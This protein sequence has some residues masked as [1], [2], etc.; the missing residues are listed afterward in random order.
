MLTVTGTKQKK[1]DFLSQVVSE[2]SDF[3]FGHHC[4]TAPW[5][6]TCKL[7][8]LIEQI[9]RGL[10]TRPS[11]KLHV[12]QGV[13]TPDTGY[14]LKNMMGSLKTAVAHSTMT[15]LLAWLKSKTRCKPCVNIVIADFIELQDFPKAVIL[16][17]LER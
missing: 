7:D 15:A 11:E 13:L 8:S 3:W 5:A 12:V 14:I 6:N 4:I 17:N 9:E 10:N 2:N 16:L 1:N